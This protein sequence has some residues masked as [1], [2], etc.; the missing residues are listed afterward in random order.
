MSIKEKQ[1]ENSILGLKGLTPNPREGAK[2]TSTI[3][4][5]GAPPVVHPGH[6]K[7]DFDGLKPQQYLNNLPK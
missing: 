2:Q 5:K 3:H 7:F 6:S 1:L 4:V